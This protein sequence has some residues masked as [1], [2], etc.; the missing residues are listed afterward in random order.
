VDFPECYAERKH[1]KMDG[2]RTNLISLLHLKKNK[3][4]S[5]RYKDLDDLTHLDAHDKR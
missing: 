2:V 3:K 1:E 5:G 4:A